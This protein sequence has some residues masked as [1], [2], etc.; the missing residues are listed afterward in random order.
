MKVLQ[1]FVLKQGLI[2]VVSLSVLGFA[3]GANAYESKSIREK[4]VRVDVRPVSLNIGEPAKFEVRLNTHSVDLSY[5]MVGISM[6]TDDT[7]R[8]YRPIH[9]DGSPPGGHHRRGI[10]EF[11]TLEGN[12]KSVT[13]VIKDIA[14]VPER[15]F[16]W[17][18]K[19]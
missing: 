15:I 5:D 4:R 1:R 6:L 3:I 8:N 16:E 14:G 9:W 19:V 17:N 7:G 13:L 2:L 10:L 18:L 11:P 12:P